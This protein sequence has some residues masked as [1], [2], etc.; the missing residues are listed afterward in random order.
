MFKTK[1][2]VVYISVV[3][4][5][6]V[7]AMQWVAGKD[8]EVAPK[9][10]FER[11]Q[12]IQ[13][14]I[15]SYTAPEQPDA[16]APS[17]RNIP[18]HYKLAAESESLELYTSPD[19][20]ELA[21]KNK[22]N[23]YV[24]SSTPEASVLEQERLNDEWLSAMRSPFL[25]YYFDEK[26]MQRRGSYLST[27]TTTE[28]FE[29]VPGGVKVTYK[30]NKLDITF[31]M[32]VKLENDSLVVKLE[33]ADIVEGGAAKLAS[34]QPLP[35][36]GAVHKNDVSGYI[37][38][39]D[40]S[41]ALIRFQ[42]QHPRYDQ[43]YEGRI[44]GWDYAVESWDNQ[45]GFNEQPIVIPVFGMVHGVKH[46][47]FVAMIE[48]GKHRSRIIA[49]PSG[50]NTNFYW[51][52]PQFILRSSYFQP[53]SKNMG[54]FNTF[55]AQRNKEDRQVR[56]TF[57]TDQAADYVGMA[58]AY[59]TYLEDNG[60]IKPLDI[61]R[62]HIPMHIEMLGAEKEPGVLSSNIVKMTS[63]AEAEEIVDELFAAGIEH[64]SVAFRGWSNGGIYRSNPDRFPVEKEL[65]GEKGLKELKESLAAKGVPLYLKADYTSAFGKN[66]NFNSK[67]DAVRSVSNKIMSY[68]QYLWLDQTSSSDLTIYFMNPNK[69][70]KVAEKD[71]KQFV[72]LG[73]DHIALEQDVLLSDHN[74]KN[75][76]TRAKTA[77][78]QARIA[79]QLLSAVDSLAYYTPNDYMWKHTGQMLRTPLYSSQFM[80]ATDTVPFLQ[81]ALHGYIDYFAPDANY[82]ANPQES[83]LRMIEYGAYPAYDVTKEP[84]WKLK[85]TLSNYL[86]TSYFDDWKEEMQHT[87]EQMDSVLKEVQEATIEERNVLDWGVVEVV[88]SNGKTVVVNYRSEDYQYKQYVVSSMGF[89]LIGGE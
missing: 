89:A 75:K 86:Y 27:D 20:Q 37:F 14:K 38:I 45:I 2:L 11:D 3:A 53:T 4:L 70:L 34:I 82:N 19:M 74:P 30:M 79:E 62:E 29:N 78:N 9:T 72:K 13:Y 80:F 77:E 28:A 84:S 85:N 15:N 50:V 46:N 40:G 47:G 61:A 35:F 26:S 42:S 7:G 68:K 33:D 16:K 5:L 44:Y 55:Q 64:I 17:A 59:R 56:Y 23:G 8:T 57:L 83:L 87:Y 24:W 39:P 10:T 69:A 31:S 36:L 73:I 54:G 67:S 18:S 48:G 1:K 65:G 12:S 52:S 6:F 41:G 60:V 63:F 66:G 76:V 71:A 25:V 49:Y 51:A 32:E 58:K 81:I 88:Y 43:A 22:R 21:I